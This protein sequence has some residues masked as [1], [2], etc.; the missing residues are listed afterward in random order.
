[1][2]TLIIVLSVFSGGAAIGLLAQWAKLNKCRCKLA[3]KEA[4]LSSYRVSSNEAHPVYYV[5]YIGDNRAVVR[6]TEVDGMSI[7]TM[8]K[9]FDTA[10]A[11]Y[12]YNEASELVNKLT[13]KICYN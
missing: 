2:L 12:N 5:E 11:E 8:I 4:A 10:D 9:I 6:L 7:R 3:R 1:M 13:E